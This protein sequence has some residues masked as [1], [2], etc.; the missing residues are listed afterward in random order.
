M[1][2][3]REARI[4]SSVLAPFADAIEHIAVFGSRA[5][6]TARPSSDIDLAI[7][8]ALTEAQLARLWTLFDESSLAVTVDLIDYHRL[9]NSALRR[10]IEAVGKVLF[11][12]EQ[13]KAAP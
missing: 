6:G 10:H 13:L 12:G 9:E 1:L 2:T 5:L 8:G 4:V 7:Y 11:T 3:E